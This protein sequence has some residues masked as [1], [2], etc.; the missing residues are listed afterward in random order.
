LRGD[1]LVPDPGGPGRNAMQ[2]I[3]AHGKELRFVKRPCN[4]DRC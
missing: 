4:P 1:Q 2:A 3:V